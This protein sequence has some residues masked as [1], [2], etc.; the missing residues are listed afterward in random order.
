MKAIQEQLPK[1]G[2]K[3]T[4]DDDCM[5]EVRP[6]TGRGAGLGHAGGRA[7]QETKPRCKIEIGRAHV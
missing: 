6:G 3:Q 4:E 5:E 1:N 2:Q 7:A